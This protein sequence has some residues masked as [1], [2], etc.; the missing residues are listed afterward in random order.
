M[1][2]KGNG[3]KA[4]HSAEPGVAAVELEEQEPGVNRPLHLSGGGV[5]TAAT[6]RSTENAKT[7][8]NFTIFISVVGGERVPDWL[9]VSG[10]A[11]AMVN[12]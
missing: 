3:D 2:A 5:S 1:D 6:R 10:S 4:F 7:T 9:R 12:K 8:V 11:L